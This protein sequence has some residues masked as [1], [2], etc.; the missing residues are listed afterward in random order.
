MSQL[1]ATQLGIHLC[2]KSREFYRLLSSLHFAISS[3]VSNFIRFAPG[4]WLW[5]K[6]KKLSFQNEHNGCSQTL[7]MTVPGA[8]HKD[9][10]VSDSLDFYQTLLHLDLFCI[11]IS[12]HREHYDSPYTYTHTH[13]NLYIKR[14]L[15]SSVYHNNLLALMSNTNTLS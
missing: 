15:T 7:S 1:Q 6:T 11:I 13:Y 9:V 12:K 5:T 2:V 8:P 14:Y 4:P 3:G 10:L